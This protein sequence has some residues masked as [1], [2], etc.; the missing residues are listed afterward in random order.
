MLKK[1]LIILFCMLAGAL[2]A[3]VPQGINYQAVARDGNGDILSNQNVT[4]VFNLRNSSNG[5]ID[6]VETHNTS[7]NEFGLFNVII[8][9]GSNPSGVFSDLD[10]SNNYD[11]GVSVNAVNLGFTPF[12]SVPY[13]LAVSPRRQVIGVAAALFT[14]NRDGV[15]FVNSLGSG[16]VTVNSAPAGATTVLNAP[17]S[18]PHGARVTSFTAYYEDNS[19]V[20][21]RIW[22]AKEDYQSSFEIAAEIESSGSQPGIQEETLNTNFII[23][24]ETGGYYL[25]VFCTDWNASGAKRIKGAKVEYLY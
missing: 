2:A 21:L 23:N 8:G 6:Y 16:S 1:Q 4:V 17:L 22:I 24:N 10:W 12:Q 9:E 11:L 15:E 3:Q 20:D 18:L 14:P 13:A 7:T 25:R 5:F 19:E